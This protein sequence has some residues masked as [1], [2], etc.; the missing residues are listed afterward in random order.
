MTCRRQVRRRC[1]C[2]WQRHQKPCPK[3]HTYNSG[4]QH[5]SLMKTQALWKCVPGVY[6]TKRLGCGF[7]NVY[8]S[9][10]N[11]PRR[12]RKPYVG[13]SVNSKVSPYVSSNRGGSFGSHRA[14]QVDTRCRHC[15][16]RV[17]F[18][19]ATDRG[20]GRGRRRRVVVM[21]AGRVDPRSERLMIANGLDPSELIGNREARPLD[22][23]S[24][25]ELI[26]GCNLRN[27]G[28]Q[29]ERDEIGFVRA[30]NYRRR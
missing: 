11:M 4:E 24:L 15:N 8:Q 29:T 23:W 18:Q 30:K 6:G 25:E 26:E 17:R 16:V 19:L 22:E 21:L 1:G 3:P 14:R 10:K 7:W 27:R 13:L 20:D 5:H 2:W 9:K 28:V 12:I